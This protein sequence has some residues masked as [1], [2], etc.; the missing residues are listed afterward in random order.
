M[1]VLQLVKQLCRYYPTSSDMQALVRKHN[2]MQIFCRF[3]CHSILIAVALLFWLGGVSVAAAVI[4]WGCVP[5][6]SNLIP[7]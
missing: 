2:V 7:F 1:G 6:S 4:L 5:V 3:S